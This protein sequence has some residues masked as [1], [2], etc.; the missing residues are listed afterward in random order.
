MYITRAIN[1]INLDILKYAESHIVSNDGTTVHLSVVVHEPASARRL[2]DNDAGRYCSSFWKCDI[3]AFFSFFLRGWFYWKLTNITKY[4]HYIALYS[5][6]IFNY[7]SLRLLNV[8]C[9]QHQIRMSTWNNEGTFN[10]VSL[11]QNLIRI[12]VTP[13][14]VCFAFL[15]FLHRLIDH[16]SS[17]LLQFIL[18]FM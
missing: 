10:V 7:R 14:N 8:L 11:C 2:V 9:K 16:I 6:S 5:S 1:D 4:I 3:T 12:P 15:H 17:I 13:M 18:Q